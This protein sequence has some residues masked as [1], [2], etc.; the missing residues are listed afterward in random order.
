M[1]IDKTPDFTALSGVLNEMSY[2]Y[3]LFVFGC[4]TITSR[5]H[6]HVITQR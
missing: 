6:P 3:I 4:I 1:I 5:R 2:T